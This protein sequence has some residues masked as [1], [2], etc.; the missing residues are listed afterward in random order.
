MRMKR[1]LVMAV[2]VSVPVPTADPAISRGIDG[3]NKCLS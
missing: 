1:D 3:W 2:T